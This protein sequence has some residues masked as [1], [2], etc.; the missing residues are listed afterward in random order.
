[1]PYDA[2]LAD[3][4]RAVLAGGSPADEMKMFGG[5]SFMISGNM[6][7]G[8]LTGELVLRVAPGEADAVLREPH[9]RP[10]DFTGR[11]MK[12]WIYVGALALED[13]ASLRAWVERGAAYARSLPP[14]GAKGA[15]KARA[16]PRN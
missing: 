13:D 15:T 16:K 4:V 3:R 10:M 9:V 1:M 12:G 8:V 11:P 5:L 6:A 7:V 14:K 2:A